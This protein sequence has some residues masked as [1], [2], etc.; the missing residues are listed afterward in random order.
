MRRKFENI[1][2][3]DIVMYAII[4][5]KAFARRLGATSISYLLL[6]FARFRG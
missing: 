2:I 1:F 5:S 6:N 4:T 3:R